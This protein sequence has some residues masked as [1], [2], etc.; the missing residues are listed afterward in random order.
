[1][2]NQLGLP[3]LPLSIQFLEVMQRGMGPSNRVL[4]DFIDFLMDT[5]WYEVEASIRSRAFLTEMPSRHFTTMVTDPA[6]FFSDT[7][8]G[9]VSATI[10]VIST[11]QDGNEGV[12]VAR[13]AINQAIVPGKTTIW[14]EE[15]TG[16]VV[17]EDLPSDSCFVEVTVPNGN[18]HHQKLDGT[19]ANRSPTQNESVHFRGISNKTI[20][21]AVMSWTLDLFS[22]SKFTQKKVFTPAVTDWGDSGTVLINDENKA[23]GFAF[24]RTALEEKISWSSWIWADSVFRAHQLQQ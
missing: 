11:N 6:L 7:S 18:F 24:E 20:E 4:F 19:L 13:H 23:I 2:Y 9:H 12:T 17:S 10:G 5:N 15:K 14:V 1:M 3:F 8:T 22:L 16:V 21:T